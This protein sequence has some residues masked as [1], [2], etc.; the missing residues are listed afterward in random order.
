[1]RFD[2]LPMILSVQDEILDSIESD[3]AS[4]IEEAFR[5]GASIRELAEQFLSNHEIGVA[6][7]AIRRLLIHRI[8]DQEYT[9]LITWKGPKTQITE[10]IWIHGQSPDEKR[11]AGKAGALKSWANIYTDAESERLQML[12]GDSD[13]RLGT[14]IN[15][16]KIAEVLNREFHGNNGVRTSE[17]VRQQ[18][19]RIN[20]KTKT[21]VSNLL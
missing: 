9:A 16:S 1:M 17:N 14:R 2:R 10:W 15:A 4:A 5:R 13:Y 11:H 20:K 18:V 3:Q 8:P 21:K 7:N 12:V 19:S 6:W